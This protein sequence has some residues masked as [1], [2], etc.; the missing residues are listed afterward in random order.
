[1]LHEI[2]ITYRLDHLKIVATITDNGSNFFKAFKEFGISD[3]YFQTVIQMN[4]Y[5][6]IYLLR[7]LPNLEFIKCIV[8]K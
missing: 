5:I 8:I 3:E 6:H 7:F 1:M 4:I 2:H